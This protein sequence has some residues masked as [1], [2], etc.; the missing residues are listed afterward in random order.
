MDDETP[1]RTVVGDVIIAFFR[2]T[3]CGVERARRDAECRVHSM[4]VK[5]DA[6]VDTNAPLRGARASHTA[7]ARIMSVTLHTTVGDIKTELFCADAPK[8]CE[9]FLALCASHYY[10]GCVFHRCV[11]QFMIQTGDPTGTGR[12]GQSIYGAPFADELVPH[13]KF[14]RR[15]FL[16]MANSGPNTNGSQF[17]ISF[18]KLPH[19]DG[20][21]TVFGRVI[22]GHGTLD[23]LERLAVDERDRP[24]RD[25]KIERVTIHANPLA[26]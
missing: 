7:R 16:A 20:R 14:S 19:L 4:D 15:G 17:F 6:T 24:V 25:V 2:V 5:S 11:K 22:D 13:L 10:D 26:G 8:S 23:A 3:T 18:A 1:T 9:N 12:G 21:V